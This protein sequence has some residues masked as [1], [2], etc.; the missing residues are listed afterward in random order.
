[1]SAK[2]GNLKICFIGPSGAGKTTLAR[3]LSRETGIPHIP[4]DEI[5]WDMDSGD[6]L[7]RSNELI[8][9][10]TER[11][12]SGKCWIVEG[13]YDKRLLPFFRDANWIL[14]IQTSLYVRVLRILK[15]YVQSKFR[16]AGP[17]ETFSNT[18]ELIR[19]TSS[20]PAKL[21]GFF[22]SHPELLEKTLTV[23]TYEDIAS[24]TG[25]RSA[26]FSDRR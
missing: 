8:D 5:Y 4:F 19:F 12:R 20:Y 23:S 16:V 25:S 26:V 1:M 14:M 21:S 11:V 6:Y 17:V 2:N 9:E 3:R 10:A 22:Q 13:S 24:R 15:R 7:K 18:I